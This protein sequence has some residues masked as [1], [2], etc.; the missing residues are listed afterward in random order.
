MVDGAAFRNRHAPSDD[1]Q[2]A[3]LAP[4]AGRGREEE[5]PRGTAVPVP[6]PPRGRRPRPRP[7]SRPRP[8]GRRGGARMRA[9][10]PLPAAL[11]AVLLSARFLLLAAGPTA[12]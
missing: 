1:D 6:V 11:A 5:A 9:S 4:R 2:V 3:A 7:R 10:R 8:P 12:A